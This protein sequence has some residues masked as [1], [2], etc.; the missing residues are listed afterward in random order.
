M[1]VSDAI[2][3]VTLLEDVKAHLTG[4]LH[5]LADEKKLALAGGEGD[6]VDAYNRELEETAAKLQRCKDGIDAIKGMMCG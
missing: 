5:L 1:T 3:L 2:N 4:R 6:Y